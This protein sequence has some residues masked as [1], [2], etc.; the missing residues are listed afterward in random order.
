MTFLKQASKQLTKIIDV[1]TSFENIQDYLAETVVI[2]AAYFLSFLSHRLCSH[3]SAFFSACI[4]V[5]WFCKMAL[6]CM[7][8]T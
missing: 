7:S 5:L 6:L 2:S 4:I 3:N 1:C 8:K